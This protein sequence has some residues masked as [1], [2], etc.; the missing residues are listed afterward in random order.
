MV[1]D[2]TIATLVAQAHGPAEATE[3]LVAAANAAGGDDN[4]TVIV[5]ELVEGDPPERP[6]RPTPA[7][8]DP[9]LPPE[10]EPPADH[11]TA[12]VDPSGQPVV[13]H[14]AGR[15]S[16]WPALLLIAAILL[17][18]ALALWWGIAR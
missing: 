14:G 13:R 15:G 6:V 8:I 11:D 16:R 7:P 18:G 3:A 17:V 4:I 2:E 10:R 12:A 9:S 5:F 1:R